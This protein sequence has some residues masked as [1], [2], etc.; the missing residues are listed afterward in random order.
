[1]RKPGHEIKS[2]M[3]KTHVFSSNLF[4]G[5]LNFYKRSYGGE[6]LPPRPVLHATI[7][8]NVLLDA[9]DGQILDLR[10]RKGF[11]FI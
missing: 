7:L 6:E 1:M 9:T 5:E 8:L 4:F 10:D 3:K 11:L 2:N